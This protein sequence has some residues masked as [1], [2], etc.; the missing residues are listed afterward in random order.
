MKNSDAE[1]RALAEAL[2]R[3]AELELR[4]QDARAQRQ[5][6]SDLFQS[7]LRPAAPDDLLE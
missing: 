4:W 6:A 7:A 5:R 2:K 3:A 1:E